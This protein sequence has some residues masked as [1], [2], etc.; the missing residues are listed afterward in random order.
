MGR[1]KRIISF[2]RERD[3]PG[4]FFELL[5]VTIGVLL[6]ISAS[7]WNESRIQNQ[8]TTQIV[9]AMRQDLR[10]GVAVEQKAGSEVDTGL[11]EFASARQRGER[12]VP[13]FYRI[14]GAE[15]APGNIWE[16]ALQTGLANSVNP[17]LLYDLGFFYSERQGIGV[18]FAHYA[19]FVEDEVLP[20]AN[21]PGHFY[22]MT[23]ALK[24]EYT[25]NME[26]LRDWRSF[27]DVTV[28]TARCLDKR[29]ANPNAPGRSCRAN[30]GRRYT[31]AEVLRDAP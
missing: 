6:G 8:R 11:A 19:R 20:Y 22:E 13:F 27:I 12:P 23:G 30:Y 10:D 9:E 24:P 21:D 26:R 14:P 16:A 2:F 7:N 15:N 3:W 18:R 31:P 5:V 28:T 1:G 17:D 4:M 29:F 25:A